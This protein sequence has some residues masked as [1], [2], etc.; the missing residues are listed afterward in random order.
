[1]NIHAYTKI[2]PTIYHEEAVLVETWQRDLYNYM[3]RKNNYVSDYCMII[4]KTTSNAYYNNKN[5]I[6][7]YINSSCIAFCS[8]ILHNTCTDV[9]LFLQ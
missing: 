5:T 6:P 4:V 2:H 7:F 8:N 1:M 9:W 3:H